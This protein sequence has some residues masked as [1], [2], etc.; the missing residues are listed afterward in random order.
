V[1]IPRDIQDTQP[2]T[3]MSTCD[4]DAVA[5]AF[6]CGICEDLLLEP[7]TLVC[8][9]RSFCKGCLRLWIRTNAQNGGIPKCPGG[10]GQKVPY[11]LPKHSVALRSAMEQLLPSRLALRIKEAE[12]EEDELCAGGYKVWQ[13]VAANRDVLYGNSLV[14]RQGTPGL[15]LGDCA[16]GVHV[17]VK[18]DEREDGSELCVNLTPDAVMAPLPGGFRLRQ[19]VVAL[20]DLLLTTDMK[21]PLGSVG[22]VIGSFSSDRVTVLFEDSS[23]SSAAER[24]KPF[25]D[26]PVSVHTREISAQRPLVGGFSIAQKVQAA[27]PLMVGSQVVVQAGCRGTVLGE[28]SDSRLTIAFDTPE[29]GTQSC[30]NVMPM[31]ILPWCESPAGY[32]TGASVLTTHHLMSQNVL[33]VQAG[34]RGVVLSGVDHSQV[35]VLFEGAPPLPIAST[36]LQPLPSSDTLSEEAEAAQTNCSCSRRRIGSDEDTAVPEDR[37][38]VTGDDICEDEDLSDAVRNADNVDRETAHTVQSPINCEGAGPT[39]VCNVD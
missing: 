12:Q 1:E 16:D 24:A 32:P 2:S 23:A 7:T 28:F 36:A 38:S 26:F 34:T 15:I 27:M 8:C 19:K 11:H 21:V 5:E 6:S 25:P 39:F 18:F 9:G 14:V 10:C 20:F 35:L 33:I 37:T 31:E 22:V 4:E 17:T 29:D 13:E 3:T 30:F